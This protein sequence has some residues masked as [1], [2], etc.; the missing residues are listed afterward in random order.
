MSDNRSIGVFDSGV[1]GLTVVQALFER[2]PEESIVYFGD[3]ARVPYGSKSPHVVQRFAMQDTK[4]LL[5]QNVKLI[6]VA[7]HTASSL[8]MDVLLDK[9]DVPILGVVTPGINGAMQKTSNHQIG[10]I[11]T[12]A[13]VSSQIYENRIQHI[14]PSAKVYPQACPLFVPLA[15]EGWLNNNVTKSIAEIY[16]NPLKEKN[17]DTLILGCTHYPLLKPLII[18]V[19]GEGV[20]VIDSAEETAKSVEQALI[21]KDL[22]SRAGIEPKHR[23]YVSDIP[24]QFQEIGE[25]FLGRHIENIERVDVDS[26]AIQNGWEHS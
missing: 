18:S 20:S 2:L 22:S 5:Q 14:D 4:F 17:I 9:V 13:T 10:I 16:L 21:E 3:T 8:A 24:Y 19:M 7:C 1:G 11:G 26:M 15:E 23:F 12:K 25:R 6:V